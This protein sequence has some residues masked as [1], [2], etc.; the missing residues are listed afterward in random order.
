MERISENA[1]IR[2][3]KKIA[4]IPASEAAMARRPAG[5]QSMGRKLYADI[6]HAIRRLECTNA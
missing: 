6:Q 3:P 2:R 1:V 4:Q 5:I